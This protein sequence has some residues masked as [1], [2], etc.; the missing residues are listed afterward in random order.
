[1]IEKEKFKRFRHT[2]ERGVGSTLGLV[3]TLVAP[4]ASSLLLS[5]NISP[6]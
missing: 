2:L 6:E 3:Q 5:F 4:G 1:M